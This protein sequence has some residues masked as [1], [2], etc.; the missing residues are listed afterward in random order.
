[1]RG[2]IT[3]AVLC[4]LATP[5]AAVIVKSK[6]GATANVSVRAAPS[7]Q[8]LIDKLDDAGYRIEEMGGYA[9]RRTNYSLH[10]SGN[11]IDINQKSRNVVR[12][13]LPRNHIAIANSC[14]VVDAAQWD[15]DPDQGHFQI[16]GWAGARYIAPK[17][18][19]VWAGL[20]LK[21]KPKPVEVAKAQ[22]PQFSNDVIRFA[23]SAL[24]NGTSVERDW[25]V[26]EKA[27]NVIV[28]SADFDSDFSSVGLSRVSSFDTRFSA[29]YRASR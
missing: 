29:S 28:A 17:P 23:F 19:T 15:N 7:F 8:C 5:A 27:E 20:K 6:S 10:P 16:G 2:I 14:G 22:P 26:F 13:P 24:M 12:I 1:M 21:P 3:T 18:L 9:H 4:A 25:R 11:A